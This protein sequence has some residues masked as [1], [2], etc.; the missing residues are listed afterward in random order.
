MS[1]TDIASFVDRYTVFILGL[2][3]ISGFAGLLPVISCVLALNSLIIN[4]IHFS[5]L[6]AFAGS[7]CVEMLAL[8]W[9]D[10]CCG[11]ECGYAL[12][13]YILT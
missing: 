4:T 3:F 9:G 1:V 7:F 10:G 5:G 11:N 2:L 6:H 13:N 8:W 12:G